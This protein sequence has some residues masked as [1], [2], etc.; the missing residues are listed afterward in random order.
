MINYS[1]QVGAISQMT[2]IGELH[3]R[4]SILQD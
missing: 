4:N 2:V 1:W 3:R